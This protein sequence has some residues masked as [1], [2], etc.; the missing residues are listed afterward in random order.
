M[1][2]RT[3]LVLD[4]ESRRAARQLAQRYGCSMSEAIRRAVVRQ[5]DEV[6]GTSP[7]QRARRRE[8]LQRLFDLFEDADPAAEVRRLKQEDEGF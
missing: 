6:L 1:P 8:I 4:E 2:D 3:S 7:R 5:R